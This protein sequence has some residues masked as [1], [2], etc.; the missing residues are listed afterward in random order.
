MLTIRITASGIFATGP[1]RA[2][3]L[4]GRFSSIRAFVKMPPAVIMTMIELTD[5]HVSFTHLQNPLQVSER[6]Q[7]PKSSI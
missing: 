3:I 7:I 4:A 6:W 1:S 5:L 2:I